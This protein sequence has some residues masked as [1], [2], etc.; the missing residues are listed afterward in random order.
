[1]KPKD[2]NER[3]DRIA[4][5]VEK[6]PMQ[7]R[8]ELVRLIGELADAQMGLSYGILVHQEKTYT[9]EMDGFGPKTLTDYFHSFT[10]N[11]MEDLAARVDGS[12]GDCVLDNPYF[13]TRSFS[14][15]E[16]K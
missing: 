3:L 11:C 15:G 9:V 13:D 7:A 14:I 4:A 6:H 2:V 5:N 10:F 12:P 16:A 1:M 8:L